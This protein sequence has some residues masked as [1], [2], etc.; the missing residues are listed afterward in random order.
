MQASKT[1]SQG[2]ARV[3]ELLN[4]EGG[5]GARK[6]RKMKRDKDE[7]RPDKQKKKP[8]SMPPRVSPVDAHNKVSAAFC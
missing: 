5:S 6:R 3:A 1:A 8:H 4:G 7:L 2:R